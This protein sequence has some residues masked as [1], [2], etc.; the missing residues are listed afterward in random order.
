MTGDGDFV[1]GNPASF[2]WTCSHYH[3]PVLY[4]VFNNA[5]WGIEWPFIEDTTLKLALSSNNYEC[6][7]IDEPRI[8][9]AK[10]AEAFGIR[11]ETLSHPEEAEEKL[12]FGF[13]MVSRGQPALID[14][15]LEKYTKGKSSYT[16]SFKRPIMNH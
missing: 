13:D 12:K 14:V 15:H 10:L 4:L 11:A 6:V 5:C 9:F 2:L 3:I 7:D 16:Y 8:D 1:F